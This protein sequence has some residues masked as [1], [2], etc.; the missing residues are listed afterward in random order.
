MAYADELS[1]EE[2][3]LRPEAVRA[4]ARHAGRQGLRDQIAALP[5]Q[6]GI[7]RPLARRIAI[8]ASVLF[9]VFLIGRWSAEDE[10]RV[11]TVPAQA[12]TTTSERP[13]A[14]HVS[15]EQRAVNEGR[16]AQV[17]GT[18]VR[19]R[20]GPGLGGPLLGVLTDGE[21]VRVLEEHEGW[22]RVVR[23]GGM[24]GWAFGS[25]IR[26]GGHRSGRPAVVRQP[27]RV[28][29]RSFTRGE[30]V[31]AIPP[32]GNGGVLLVMPDGE[33]VAVP[34]NAVVLVD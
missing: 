3:N 14:R 11:I 18:G 32:R 22:C 34:S 29:A 19:L 17:T 7:P 2:G 21:F 6:P 10:K 25:Y 27:L 15:Q 33:E 13:P 20:G 26:G 12:A 8:G 23:N 30:K 5:V 24:L 1:D 31:L 16:A 28:G 9:V 4:F